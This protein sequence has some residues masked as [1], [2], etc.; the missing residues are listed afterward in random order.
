MNLLK[1]RGHSIGPFLGDFSLDLS[2]L[3]GV[4]AVVGPNGAGKSTLLGCWPAALDRAFPG[5]EASRGLA[6][7]ARARDSYVEAT[8]TGPGGTELTIRQSIDAVSGKGESIVTGAVPP[9]ASTSVRAFDTWRAT[10]LP[11]SSVMYATVF[12]A[13]GEAGFLGLGKA[14]RMGVLLRALGLERY[15]ARIAGARAK[16]TAEDATRVR[17][18]DALDAE[19]A[20]AVP[21][22]VAE[23]MVVG[24]A[25][26]EMTA[27][28]DHAGAVEA[29]RKAQERHG[30]LVAAFA[31]AESAKKR[32][33][34]A[35][36]VLVTATNKLSALRGRAVAER[37][38]LADAAEI[39]SAEAALPPAREALAAADAKLRETSALV[40]TVEAE[41]AQLTRTRDE[42]EKRLAAA[43]GREDRARKA[44]QGVA[45]AEAAEASLPARREEVARYE[46]EVEGQKRA[47]EA[48][49][50][51]LDAE[52]AKTLG[53]A[54][55][56]IEGLEGK[57]AQIRD[58][59]T[60]DM[61]F[62]RQVASS[63]LQESQG[64]LRSAADAPGRI[65]SLR[66]RIVN[67]TAILKAAESGEV[68]SV[69]AARLALSAAEKVAASL[70]MLRSHAAE[71]DAALRDVTVE[72][73][74]SANAEAARSVAAARLPALQQAVSTEGQARASAASEVS[75]LERIAAK[76]PALAAAEARLAE[77][78][79][80]IPAAEAA[81]RDAESALADAPEAPAV[82]P[83]PDV[84]AQ[85]RAVAEADAR[86]KAAAGR[87][88]VAAKGLDDAR[89]A[90]ARIDLQETD[91]RA[92]EARLSDWTRLERDYRELRALEIDAAGPE[93]GELATAILRGA[94]GSRWTV[95]LSMSRASA[96]GKK[97]VEECEVRLID[98]FRGREDTSAYLSF[99]EA[100]IVSEAL[101]D[102]L[103]AISCRRY[104]IQRPVFVR[105]ETAAPL[106]QTN[107]MEGS[108]SDIPA[109]HQ[110]LALLRSVS[111]S[112]GATILFVCHDPALAPLADHIVR[113]E[114]GTVRIE[115]GGANA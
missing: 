61:P 20:R 99:G 93:I 55:K 68:K 90:A 97:E 49:T 32:R 101:F 24:A 59:A 77:V 8:V 27:M 44:A 103:A 31:D 2:T 86:V 107:C 28:L 60:D 73:Q 4:V 5:R 74:A 65:A 50:T 19:R 98:T 113:V 17:L 51:E 15:E 70:P 12:A 1:L 11:P 22:S 67:E 111:R 105:D 78:E 54:E 10:H 30:A 46:A 26:V 13:Q 21:V 87:V 42:A 66:D 64:L 71:A 43:K 115:H 36:A 72:A 89:E 40:T 18:K 63:A 91:L 84:A 104:G 37:A 52:R 94:F 7:L 56:R 29:L 3:S 80:Q 76:A 96:D 23:S 88:A 6:E 81:V 95:S 112:T 47:I 75:R 108:D 62:V 79:G 82:E 58:F 85:E 92:S 45:L 9:L 25:A 41:V 109:S 110:Y 102:A 16:G 35:S 33:A 83:V 106:S 48:L 69:R 100:A 14:E 38:A 34:E 39:R 114:D 57:H 53:V